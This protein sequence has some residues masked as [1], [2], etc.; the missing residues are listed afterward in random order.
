M[1]NE[2]E[3]S[4]EEKVELENEMKQERMK[5][6]VHKK[7]DDLESKIYTNTVKW[8]EQ[9]DRYTKKRDAMLLEHSEADRRRKEERRKIKN[10][11]AYLMNP[12]A[13]A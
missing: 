12:D 10:D 1:H 2:N 4:F 7:F 8:S 5:N 3:P 11:F 13:A 9:K 6:R